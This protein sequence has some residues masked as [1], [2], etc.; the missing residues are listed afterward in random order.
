MRYEY[1]ARAAWSTLHSPCRM[2]AKWMRKTMSMSGEDRE[3]KIMINKVS[4]I[5]VLLISKK[6]FSRF[7]LRSSS[8]WL[9]LSFVYMRLFVH[10]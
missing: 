9:A 10:Q 6:C 8:P 1:S 4:K 5:A 3:E 7:S 2:K